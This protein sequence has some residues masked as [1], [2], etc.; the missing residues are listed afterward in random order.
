[1]DEILET[2]K[3]RLGTMEGCNTEFSYG[4]DQG[5]EYAIKLIKQWNEEN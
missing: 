5:I 2:L 4:Y 3:D 1:M